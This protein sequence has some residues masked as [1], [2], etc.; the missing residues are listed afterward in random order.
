[1]RRGRG[2]AAAR[3]GCAA[4]VLAGVTSWGGDLLPPLERLPGGPA[5]RSTL[6]GTRD[7][8]CLEDTVSLWRPDGSG[9]LSL[10]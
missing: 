1:M 4:G 2:G 10:E 8:G 9:S 7:P 3:A 6:Q 5:R